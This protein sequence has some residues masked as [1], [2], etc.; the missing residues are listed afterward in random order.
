MG[1]RVGGSCNSLR[2]KMCVLLKTSLLIPLPHLAGPLPVSAASEPK[3]S[4]LRLGELSGVR[5]RLPSTGQRGGAGW[6]D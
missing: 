5:Q 1:E 2:D 3:S 4:S 6:T